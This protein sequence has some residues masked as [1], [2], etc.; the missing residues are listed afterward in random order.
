MIQMSS[1]A[2]PGGSSALRTRCTRRSLF[3]TVPS[4]SHADVEAGKHDVGQLRRLRQEDVL[5][6]QAVEALE[7]LHRVRSCRPRTAAGFSPIT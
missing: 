2:S 5:H 6:D 1:R 4:V 3:V 7:Q